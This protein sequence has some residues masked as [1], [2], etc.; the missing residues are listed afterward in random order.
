MERENDD[1]VVRARMT[2]LTCGALDFLGRWRVA[3]GRTNDKPNAKLSPGRQI[4]GF[5]RRSTK[6]SRDSPGR[7]SCC[8]TCGVTGL[9]D[10]EP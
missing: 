7:C 9:V 2:E 10:G 4:S 5:D 6:D 1:G 3:L 8:R